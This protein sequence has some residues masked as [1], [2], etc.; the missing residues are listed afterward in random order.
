MPFDR[1][2]A[3]VIKAFGDHIKDDIYVARPAVVTAIYPD[4]QT[5]DVQLTVKNP[6]HDE[7]GNTIFEDATGFSDVPLGVVR[8]GGFFIWVPIAVGDSVML[9]W[10]DLSM[11]AWRS[12]GAMPV[13]PIWVGK[14]T[15]DSPIAMPM[16]APDAK[17]FADIP[18]D[19]DKVIIGKD[20]AISQVKISDTNIELGS[21]PPPTDFVALASKVDSLLSDL[22]SAINSWVPVPNDGG[23]ALKAALGSWL[24]ASI[25]TGSTLIRA[26]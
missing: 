11:D 5:V 8:G 2:P 24:A 10:S 12:A 14:H 22:Q 16:V 21:N 9:L 3:E 20:G 19:P 7:F 18:L 17:F 6:L 15:A 25:A 4:R 1:T 23:A 13:E 26:K